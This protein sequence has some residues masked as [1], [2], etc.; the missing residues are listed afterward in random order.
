VAPDERYSPHAFAE[1]RSGPAA[2]QNANWNMLAYVAKC[3]GLSFPRIRRLASVWCRQRA[4]AVNAMYRA[5]EDA[6]DGI[7]IE[8]LLV[9]AL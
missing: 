4:Y 6:S 8:R 9:S 5:S 3:E 1:Q 7:S 2:L